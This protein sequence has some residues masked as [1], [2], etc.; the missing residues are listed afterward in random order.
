MLPLFSK[1]Y[2]FPPGGLHQAHTA[3]IISSVLFHSVRIAINFDAA[4]RSD[5]DMD[6]GTFRTTCVSSAQDIISL[7]RK[8]R[9][10][11][12]LKHA[13]ITFVYGIVQAS[14]A[15]KSLSIP[16]EFQYLMQTL[17]ETSVTWDLAKQAWQQM[18]F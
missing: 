7:V 2:F 1:A 15:I 17:E 5:L 6:A 14:R 9:V 10:Q 8:Y 18:A 11:F 3:D 16:Q 13:P 4:T 12:G